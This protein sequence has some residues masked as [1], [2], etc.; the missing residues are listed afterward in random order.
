MS[1]SIKQRSIKLDQLIKQIKSSTPA[2]IGESV[3]ARK[4]RV[5]NLLG[6]WPGFLKY[7]F[8]NWASSDFAPFHLRGGNAVLNF[9]EKKNVFAWQ[10]SRNL[11]KTTFWQMFSM[12]LSLRSVSGLPH[13]FETG[14]WWSKTYDQ[15]SDMLTSVRLQYEYNQKLIQDFGEFKTFGQWDE[16]SFSTAQGIWWKA[17]GKGQSPRGSKKDEKRPRIVIGDD[18]DDDEELRSSKRLEQSWQWI[19]DAL[20]PVVDISDEALFVFLNNLLAKDSL[21]ARAYQMADYK[22]QVNL[23][24]NRGQPSWKA[25]HTLKDCQYMIG[26]I[27]TRAA[28]KEYFNNPV[29]EGKVFKEEWIQDKSMKDL[30]GYFALISYLDPSFKSK[31]NADHKALV[32][33]GLK[34]GEIHVIKTFCNS[35][36]VEEMVEWHYDIEQYVKKQNA[37]CEFWMEEVFLQDL[38][39]KD[40]AEAAK[41]KGWPI[42]I[43][44]DTRQKPD[45]DARISSLAGYFERGQILFNALEKENHHM[46]RLKEQLLLFEPG[47]TGIKKDGPDS[48]EGG[49]F[50][51]MEK[52]QSAQPQ[53]M[54]KRAKSKNM[55]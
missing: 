37:V 2:Q 51:I 31:K 52:V 55:Y 39:Y 15:A 20:M 26:K 13:G 32:L 7:Y 30:G 16:E 49:I 38:L 19:T 12:Y 45:K 1:R 9:K 11:S 41:R 34:D 46:Q 8:P 25:R 23:L 18:F 4:D 28:Q 48:L 5:N 53:A 10:I 42:G 43:M 35:A 44:G 21:M 17:L 22:E 24:D 47:F 3:H 29:T 14:I 50:K 33:L 40:F 27:G 54:G 36:T 6:Y